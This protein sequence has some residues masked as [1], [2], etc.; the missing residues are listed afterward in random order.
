MRDQPSTDR[1]ADLQ[2]GT[3]RIR[4]PDTDRA[5]NFDALR[6]V[7][8]LLV[9]WG[10]GQELKGFIPPIAWGTHVSTLGVD[11]F[12]VISGYLVTDS[13]NRTPRLRDFAAKRALRI[14]PGL[15]ACVV[16]TSFVLGP[17]TTRLPVADY[18]AHHGTWQYLANIGFY[19]KLYLPGVF[20][21]R[22]GFGAVNG[23]LWSLL[24]EVLCY[25]TVPLLALLP[26]YARMTGVALLGLAT[27]LV[28]FELFRRNW[29]K[30]VYSADVKYVLAQ[31]P[32]FCAGALL[33]LLRTASRSELF[34]I[35][36][37]IL[38]GL[39]SYGWTA[40]PEPWGLVLR[41]I[42]LAYLVV[43]FGCQATPGLRRA[44]R[45]GDL[46]YGMYLY[47]FPMQQLVLEHT[48]AFAITTCT[49]LTVA[50]AF[51]SWHLVERPA[52][53]LKQRLM[54]NPST[55]PADE[56]Y[57]VLDQPVPTAI[58]AARAAPR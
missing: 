11:I 7:A 53:R 18:L 12:F 10:H 52:I 16:L 36:V 19:L 34:R 50:A 42:G 45:F 3:G 40:L 26:R 35:D 56:P 14:L 8:A 31:V 13:W 21:E 32:F 15:V 27:G 30:L 48:S 43:C 29:G 23:S 57:P 47:A 4:Y 28:A 1:I 39:S 54:T 37:A 51:L 58:Q 17:L 33:C 55:V 44:A 9:I 41:W 6:L 46:S 5:N 20:A 24:P 2:P 49:A 25:M 38:V 22:R